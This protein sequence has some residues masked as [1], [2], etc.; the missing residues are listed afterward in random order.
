MKSHY[1]TTF[2]FASLLLQT[3]LEGQTY[4]FSTYQQDYVNINVGFPLTEGVWDDPGFVIPLGYG[5]TF[6]DQVI[7]ELECVDTFST[8]GTLVSLLEGNF[9]SV[10]NV[11][12]PDIIDRGYHKGSSMSTIFFAYSGTPGQRVFTQEWVNVGF[13]NGDTADGV[14]TDF[15][16]FQLQLHEASGDIIFHFGPSS[17]TNASANYEGQT[18]PSVGLLRSVSLS[19]AEQPEESLRLTGNPMFP[20]VNV[21]HE[22]VYLNGS[23][24]P[25]TVYRFTQEVTSTDVGFDHKKQS[26]F[27]P[28]PVN[29]QFWIRDQYRSDIIFPIQVYTS[30]GMLVREF[31]DPAAMD[32]YNLTTGIYEIR[33]KTVTGYKGERMMVKN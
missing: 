31:S 32:M 30:Q 19:G 22:Q 1:I 27:Y 2:L 20:E 3:T 7:T 8:G 23:I 12:G 29:G 13:A 33:Y 11:F 17:I 25:N 4:T 24:P 5:F 15:M 9:A 18:G 26:I 14:Y 6:Y 21:A 16:N 10:I 28:N